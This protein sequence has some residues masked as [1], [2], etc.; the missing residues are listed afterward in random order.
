MH[1]LQGKSSKF[2]IFGINLP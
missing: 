1:Q 2:E